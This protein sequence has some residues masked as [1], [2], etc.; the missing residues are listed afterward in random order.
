MGYF[1]TNTTSLSRVKT[2]EM[3]AVPF[4]FLFW[5]EAVVNHLAAFVANTT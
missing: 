3:I 1:T 5:E 4:K 2:A